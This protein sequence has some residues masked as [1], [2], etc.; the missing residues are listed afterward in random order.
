MF[1][2]FLTRWKPVITV[3]I[4]VMTMM[5]KP[6][7]T[8]MIIVMTVNVKTCDWAE[9]H[10]AGRAKLHTA[11]T[12]PPSSPQCP[13]TLKQNLCAGWRLQNLLLPRPLLPFTY[14][15]FNDD[16]SD[17][18]SMRPPWCAMM[19]QIMP[20]SGQISEIVPST[21]C[22]LICIYSTI[23]SVFDFARAITCVKSQPGVH[24]SC[25]YNCLP[26]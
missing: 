24:P 11:S 7:I 22:S 20:Q 8:V 15:W 10:W 3:M 23:F 16:D 13:N 5:W 9:A 25:Q 19:Q 6:G 21:I 2:A 17:E 14:L 4:S 26:S 18:A 12:A 1:V